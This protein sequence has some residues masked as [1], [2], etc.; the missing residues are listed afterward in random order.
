MMKPT[1]NDTEPPKLE[2][3]EEVPLNGGPS[4]PYITDQFNTPNPLF[5]K[6]NHASIPEVDVQNYRLTIDG[7]V[8]RPLTFTMDEVRQNYPKHTLSA[9]LQCA[10][11]RRVEMEK[12][13]EIPNELIW[14]LQAVSNAEWSGVRLGDILRSAGVDETQPYH[15]VFEGLDQ[16]TKNDQTFPFGASIPLEK[17]LQPE[18]LLAY[19]MNHEPLPLEHGFPLR[20]V[21]GGYIGARSVKW[22]TKI[23]VQAEPSDNYYQTH[24]YKLFASHITPENVN[25]DEGGFMLGE[26]AINSVITSP[27]EGETLPE[28]KVAIKGYAF[29]AGKHIERVDVSIDGGNTWTQAQLQRDES[30]W[31]WCLWHTEIPL[32]VGNYTLVVRAFDSAANTQPERVES[33]WNFKGYMNNAWHKVHIEVSDV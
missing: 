28:G 2:I 8:E 17:A 6:R 27:A 11:N 19:E 14:N 10:G 23:T 21:V 4:S 26:V 30:P 12:F 5:F 3:L 13:G 25:W 31:A 32:S 7:L 18:S 20:A 1:H 33:I 22:L 24:A 29:S 15:V 9:V 16:C